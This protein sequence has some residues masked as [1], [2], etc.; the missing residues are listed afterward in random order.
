[1]SDAKNLSADSVSRVASVYVRDRLIGWTTL[2]SRATGVTGLVARGTSS[3][4]VISADGRRV[5]FVSDAPGLVA[6]AEVPPGVPAVYLRDLMAGATI[7]VSRANGATG[8]PPTARP[9]HRR[10]RV[11][12]GW[13][14]SPPTAA[15]LAAGVPAGTLEVYVR[16]LTSGTTTLVSRGDLGGP[17]ADGASSAPAISADGG[18]VAFVSTA[19]N[20]ASGVPAGAAEIYEHTLA[21]GAITS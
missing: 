15:D 19:A 2:V 17:P 12:A 9:W 14:P 21:T 8:A 11:T 20:L 7:L 3:D 1:M 10:S 18:T 16:D 6:D 13:W 4:P 5:A